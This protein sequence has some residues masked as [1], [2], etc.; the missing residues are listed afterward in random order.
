M[1]KMMIFAAALA[2]AAAT[3]SHGQTTETFPSFIQVTGQSELEIEP[4]EIYVA[5]TIDE[6]VSRSRVTVAEQEKRMLSALQKLGID[7]AKDLQVGD[8]SGELQ[9]YVIRR[10]RVQTSK[11]YILKVGS[12][13]MLAKVFSALSDINI[14]DMRL[15]KVTRNDLPELRMRLRTEAMKD[16]K[17]NAEVLAEAIGQK[18]GKAFNIT[19]Y[20]SFGGGTVMYDKSVTMARAAVNLDEQQEDSSLSFRNLKLNYSVS[21]RFILE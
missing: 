18:A 14:S 5:I 4:N 19:D 10:D 20:N 9:S 7:T 6:S 16:A 13:D 8:M 21:A 1:K 15:S 11:S 3:Q 12:A 2:F 17:K